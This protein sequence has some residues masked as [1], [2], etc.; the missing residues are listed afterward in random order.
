MFLVKVGNECTELWPMNA[1]VPQGSVFDP[2]LYLLY[3]TDL[4]TSPEST[5]AT[6]ADDTAVI[7]IDNDPTIA[8]HKLQTSLLTIQHW[9]KKN[10][11]WKPPVLSQPTSF[12]T[13][14][15]T[16]P[17]VYINNV[18]LPQAEDTLHKH[19]LARW[20]QLGITLIKMYWLL[21]CKSTLTTSNKPLIYK[22]IL[23]PIWTYGI[24]TWGSA[25][26]S[27]IEI[28][29]QFQSKAMRMI[30]DALWYV[31]NAVIWQDLKIPPVKEEICHLSSQ[32]STQLSSHPINLTA[33][34][35]EP[36]AKRWLWRHLPIDLPTRFLV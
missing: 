35:T 2:I 19:I 36:P 13:W 10:G 6:F 23:K 5:T 20:K 1:G 14:R 18:E 11:D 4:W 24:Q 32:Y 33:N 9:L 31:P 3:T 15:E 30:T 17:S 22:A 27:N 16:C 29:E 34:L 8:S 7:A 26:T 12:T 21:R 28:L 25:S